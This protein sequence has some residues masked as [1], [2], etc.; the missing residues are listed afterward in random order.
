MTTN[1]FNIEPK[2][3]GDLVNSKCQG[4][5]ILRCVDGEMKMDLACVYDICIPG[6]ICPPGLYRDG[7]KCRKKEECLLIPKGN[8]LKLNEM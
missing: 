6:C 2:C 4:H 5:C 8:M 7:L 1:I 3:K